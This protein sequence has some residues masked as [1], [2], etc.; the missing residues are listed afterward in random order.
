[1][2]HGSIGSLLLKTDWKATGLILD[3]GL[4]FKDLVS[5]FN[6]NQYEAYLLAHIE[7][8]SVV[9]PEIKDN[10]P[11]QY[12]IKFDKT[13]SILWSNIKEMSTKEKNKP[14]YAA[15]KNLVKS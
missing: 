6:V 13:L 9:Y 7:F 2:A 3:E 15:V 14:W 1:M 4:V 11:D 8:M 5:S 10:Q 12:G